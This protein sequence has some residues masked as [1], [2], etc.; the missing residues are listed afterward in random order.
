MDQK[1]LRKIDFQNFL[2]VV[3]I[4]FVVAPVSCTIWTIVV[5]VIFEA[6]SAIADSLLNVSYVLFLLLMA[7]LIGFYWGKK[8]KCGFL[9]MVFF[10]TLL[11]PVVSFLVWGG[12]EWLPD[13]ITNAGYDFLC[14]LYGTHVTLV[15]FFP[16]VIGLYVGFRI[17][18]K[19][20][21]TIQKGEMEHEKEVE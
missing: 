9:S 5:N 19:K 8:G 14:I 12:I 3:F 20:L 2:K 10:P 13:S 18:Q 17:R 11:L 7:G 1:A 15:Y 21:Q 16:T 4:L 6:R